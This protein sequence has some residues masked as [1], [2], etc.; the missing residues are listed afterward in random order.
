MAVDQIHPDDSTGKPPRQASA[1]R[2]SIGRLV[3]ANSDRNAQAEA[4][5]LRERQRLDFRK[6]LLKLA[7]SLSGM[8]LTIRLSELE[9]LAGGFRDGDFMVEELHDLLLSKLPMHCAACGYYLKGLPARGDCPE[10][11]VKYF[12]GVFEPDLLHEALASELQ[13]PVN[14]ILP[15]TWVV[16]RLRCLSGIPTVDEEETTGDSSLT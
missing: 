15:E 4:E 1:L 2:A 13:M 12:S 9:A 5:A 11:G 14:R 6:R 10:C 7:A 3:G 16:D 8:T